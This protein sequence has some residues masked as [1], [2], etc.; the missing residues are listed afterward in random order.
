VAPR[1]EDRKLIIR[2]ISFKLVQFVCSRY[3]NVTDGRTDRQ[4][5]GRLAIAIGLPR[6]A[7]RASCG[8]PN[9]KPDRFSQLVTAAKIVGK[10]R[11][12][13]PNIVAQIT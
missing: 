3:V 1:S 10:G 13:K 2:V 9:I 4:T 7:L 6:F 12:D 8:R 11:A 5:D